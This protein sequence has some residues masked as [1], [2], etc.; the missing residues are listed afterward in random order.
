MPA[1][2]NIVVAD[3]TPVNHTFEPQSASLALSTWAEETA[4]TFEGNGRIAVAMSN[5]TSTRKTSRIKINYAQPIER[6]V[7]GV[8]KVTDTILYTFEAV[9]PSSCSM[10][11]AELAYTVACNILG[12]TQIASYL[13]NRKP[14]Y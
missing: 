13:V 8:V 7:D 6:D 3:A 14:V 9:L 11:E 2:A 12:S 1:I 4:T 5:P 10:D